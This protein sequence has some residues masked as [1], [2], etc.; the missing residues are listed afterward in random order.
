M[1]VSSLLWCESNF[2]E[3]YWSQNATNQ[4]HLVLHVP[5]EWKQFYTTGG[6]KGHDTPPYSSM[7][8]SFPSGNP[9]TTIKLV[10]STQL[11]TPNNVIS[12]IS[13]VYKPNAPFAPS[14]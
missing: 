14:S 4:L 11:H 5:K 3:M 9:S 10:L 6:K 1:I 8:V 7:H 13:D 12:V 2:S